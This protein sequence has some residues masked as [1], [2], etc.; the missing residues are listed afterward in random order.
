[1]TDMENMETIR[2]RIWGMTEYYTG[3]LTAVLELYSETELDIETAKEKIE[4]AMEHINAE[5]ELIVTRAMGINKSG[6]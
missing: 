1:M 5:V 3:Y 6:D 4:E 2:K